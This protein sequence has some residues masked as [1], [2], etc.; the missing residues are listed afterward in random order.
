MID[1]ENENFRNY[2]C[3]NYCSTNDGTLTKEDLRKVE[4]LEITTEELKFWDEGDLAFVTGCFWQLNDLNYLTNLKVLSI[5]GQP[6]KG[7]LT[8]PNTIEEVHIQQCRKLNLI[9]NNEMI[10]VKP[11]SKS[12]FWKKNM[13]GEQLLK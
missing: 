9:I 1:I 10:E 3:E 6:V 12:W 4:F 8:L 13:D 5:N 2:L 11:S 7:T